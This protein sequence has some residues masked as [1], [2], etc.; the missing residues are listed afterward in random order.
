MRGAGPAAGIACRRAGVG[1]RG[2]RRDRAGG[3]LPVV[4]RV[5]RGHRGLVEALGA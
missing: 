1:P 3:E 2:G 4:S 5:A